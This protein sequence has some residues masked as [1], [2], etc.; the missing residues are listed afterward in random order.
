MFTTEHCI[1]ELNKTWWNT[2]ESQES[3]HL[4]PKQSVA[5]VYYMNIKQVICEFPAFSSY[6]C[7]IIRHSKHIAHNAY[8]EKIFSG[9][10][11][12]T[13]LIWPVKIIHSPNQMQVANEICRRP[14]VSWLSES[15]LI[16]LH[17]NHHQHAS[18]DAFSM[19]SYPAGR[20]EFRDPRKNFLYEKSGTKNKRCKR[21]LLP[22]KLLEFLTLQNL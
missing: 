17:G 7:V 20:V 2:K 9:S 21:H 12:S 14:V 4:L 6:G 3:K 19:G 10:S 1:V 11:S 8:R 16:T 18:L 15:C 13:I 5:H 22:H